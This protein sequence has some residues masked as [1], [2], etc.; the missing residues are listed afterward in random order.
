[1]ANISKEERE[2]R[3]LEAEQAVQEL[4]KSA[5]G[6]GD[7]QEATETE[8]LTASPNAGKTRVPYGT[9]WQ[10]LEPGEPPRDPSL[11]DETPAWKA[12]KQAKEAQKNNQ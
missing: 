3:R 7:A 1:M 9:E 11:G 8:T 5:G 10:W 6:A 12:W 4:E 2:R